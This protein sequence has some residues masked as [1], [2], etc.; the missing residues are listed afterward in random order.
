MSGSQAP[1][2]EVQ[3]YQV[4]KEYARF[5]NAA[6]PHQGICQVIL[7]KIAASVDARCEG[8]IIAFPELNGLH[9]D[10]RRSLEQETSVTPYE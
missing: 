2:G 10:Y 8:K 7:P 9:H 5:F 6:R 4:F 1:P 3:L